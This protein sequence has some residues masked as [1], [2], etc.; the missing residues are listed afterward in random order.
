MK[1]Y[2]YE[3]WVAHGHTARVHSGDCHF[4]NNGQGIHKNAGDNNGRWL[5]SFDTFEIA[6]SN[7]KKLCTNS[8][9]CKFCFRNQTQ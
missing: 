9:P 4:C 1:Y 8:R 7:A 5:G 3:N 6:L 2:I